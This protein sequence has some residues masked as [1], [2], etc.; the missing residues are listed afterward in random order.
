VDAHGDRW[1]PLG[2]ALLDFHRGAVT[3]RIIVRTDLWDDEATPVEA[4]YR[5]DDQP[6]PEL[7][8]RAL[9]LCRGRILDLGAGAGRHALELQRQGFAVTA[10]DVLPESVQVM[11]DR[12]VRD[13]RC[14]DFEGLADE[15]FDTILLLMH[16]VGLVGTLDG[17]ARFLERALLCLEDGGQI[18]FDSADLGLV[19]PERYDDAHREWRAGG[20]YPGE[21]EYRLSYGDL[22][23]QPYPWLFVDPVTLTER[24]E[25]VG[26]RTEVVAWGSRGSYLARLRHRPT[27]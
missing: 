20:L 14:G 17:L 2:R 26:L 25:A 4:F 19:L 15:S 13:A 10:V 23:G 3:A 22:E 12:G 7:E 8:R 6:L 21:V 9:E 18:I 24:A 16:G 1:R 5:P 27:P 11:R